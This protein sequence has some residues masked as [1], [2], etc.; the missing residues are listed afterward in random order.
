MR[1]KIFRLGMSL[2]ILGALVTGLYLFEIKLRVSS[3]E[4]RRDTLGMQQDIPAGTLPGGPF[5]L[6][7]HTG[8]TV[9]EKDFKGS[10]LL[11]FFGYT[12]CPDVCPTVLSN[13][14]TTLKALGED[15]RH[16][17][18]LFITVDPEQDTPDVLDSYVKFFHP[19]IIG[20]TGTPEQIR[21]VTERYKAFYAKIPLKIEGRDARHGLYTVDHS[22]FMYFMGP[23]GRYLDVFQ[24][25]TPPRQMAT[26]IRQVLK[27]RS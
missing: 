13:V 26:K 4:Q 24:Y 21:T 17:R 18:P 14:A 22:A 25:G 20:L 2:I 10:F 6:V 8:R 27:E 3:G 23:D 16:V 7:D 1:S 15:V 19:S 11:V 12:H 5:T 9:T